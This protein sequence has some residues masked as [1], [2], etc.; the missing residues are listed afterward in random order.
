MAAV[1][2]VAYATLHSKAYADGWPCAFGEGRAVENLDV[3]DLTLDHV[4]DQV[5][6][7]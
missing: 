6:R 1:Y 5:A 3:Y 2:F 7:L 4:E